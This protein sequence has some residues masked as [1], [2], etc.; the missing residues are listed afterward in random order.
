MI[1]VDKRRIRTINN[2]VYSS[3]PIIYWM[4]R[5]QRIHDNWALLYAQQLAREHHTYVVI[6]F[7]I[8]QSFEHATERLIDFMFEGLNEAEQIARTYN[9]PFICRIGDPEKEVLRCI[10]TENAGALVCDMNPLLW[11]RKWKR[12][13]SQSLEIPFIEVDA[14]NIVPVWEASD[15]REYAAYTIRPKIRKKL[16][17]FLVEFPDV[18]HQ[19]NISHLHPMTDWANVRKQ[20][21]YR[22][23]IKKMDWIKSGSSNALYAA[24]MF[25]REKLLY[26]EK[27]KNNISSSVQ[28]GLSPY[29]HFGQLS[30]QRVALLVHHDDPST[31]HSASFLEELIIRKELSDNFCWYTEEYNSITSFPKWAIASLTA[32]EIDTRIYT[33]TLR[34]FENAQTHDPLWNAAQR[35]L[36]R[37]GKMNGYMR[38]YWAK[39]ILEWTKN[40]QKAMDIAIYL[41]D[42]YSLDGRDPNGYAG[43]AWSIGGVHDRPWFNRPI[44][45]MIRYMSGVSI[46]KKYNCIG[47]LQQ[48]R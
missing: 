33:Y 31:T 21:K 10:K 37:M 16:E 13:I 35:E 28:S 9:I 22:R 40:S 2:L 1:G 47:Y 45:G 30:S 26:Y 18:L 20:I 39:K 29:L 44:Y 19:N 3:G 42:L 12:N 48:H 46:Q 11:S 17:E 7:C 24:K 41:N 43:I 6:L 25:I 5:D 15:H 32:H 38:M 8:R 23:D 34:E 14:H 27:Q 4:S 36:V